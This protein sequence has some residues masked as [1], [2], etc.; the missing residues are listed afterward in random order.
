VHAHESTI[1]EQ[2]DLVERFVRASVRSW[3]AAQEDPEA[4]VD[5]ALKVKPDLNR[6]STLK[7]LQVDLDLLF[8][9]NT[10][11]QGIGHGAPEDWQHTKELL[12]QYRDLQTDREATSFYTNEFLPQ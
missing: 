5:A 4:A 7:Q 1:A 8:S 6:E 10:Q 11:D 12:T 2:P 3:E 9:P